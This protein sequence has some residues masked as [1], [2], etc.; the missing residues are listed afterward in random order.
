MTCWISAR[1]EGLTPR[2]FD[3]HPNILKHKDHV[4]TA[5][6]A[7]VFGKGVV[8]HSPKKAMLF[9]FFLFLRWVIGP[10][11]TFWFLVRFFV[12]V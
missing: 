9:C 2:L 12:F 4:V 5:L 1:K 8:V 11:P 7:Q 3:A 6:E 10:G